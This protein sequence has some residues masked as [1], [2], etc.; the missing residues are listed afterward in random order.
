MRSLEGLNPRQLEAAQHLRGPLLIIAGP[1]SGK[2]RVIV[3]RIAYLVELGNSPYRILAVTFTNKAAREMRER[4]ESLL[5]L[6]VHQLTVGTFHATCARWLRQHIHRLGMDPGFAIYDDNDQVDLVKQVL[7][8]MGVDDKRHSPRSFLSRISAAKAELVGPYQFAERAEGHWEEMCAQVYRRYQQLLLQNRALDFDDLLAVTVQLFRQHPDV[9]E[10][11]QER[12]LHLLVDEFQDTNVAQYELVKLLGGKHRNVC[13]VGDPDQSIYSWRAADI[14]NILNFERDYPDLKV[15]VLEQNYRS[16]QTIL[17]VAHAVISANRLRKD[18]NLW[19]QNERGRPVSVYEAYDERDE[20]LYVVREV[21]RQ[22]ARGAQLRDFAVMYR[23]NAQSRALED[24]FVRYGVPYRLVGGTRFYERRE[25]KDVLAYLRVL[26]NPH[27]SV[28][29]GRILNVPNRGL[30]PKTAMELARWASVHDISL[31]EA[32]RRAATEADETFSGSESP[33]AL[34]LGSRSRHLLGEF[35]A[36][37]D[38]LR[39]ELD[40]RSLPDLIDLLLERTG[41]MH[42]IRDGS[43]EGEERWSNIGELRAKARE[44]EDLGQGGLT[45]FLEEVS[46]VQDVDSYDDRANAVTLITLHAAKGLEFPCV[47]IVGLEEGLCPHSRSFDDPTAM[48]EERRLFYVGI[49]R[50]MRDLH[51]VYSFRRARWGS[52]TTSEPSRFLADIP[53]SLVRSP[54][55]GKG[56]QA[57]GR[58][59]ASDSARGVLSW[60]RGTGEG[61][62]KG[63]QE[64]PSGADIQGQRT[65]RGDGVAKFKTGDTVFHPSLGRGIVITSEASAGDEIVTVVFE[66]HGLKKLSTSFAPLT[67]S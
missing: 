7:K 4:L 2:T 60:A 65:G 3:H 62:G 5:G 61:A 23:T 66:R 28:S 16:T 64:E 26:H 20:A 31:Y 27:D 8:E 45:S 46:L 38:G 55:D 13:V 17:H 39:G 18:K 54:G 14:R 34:R 33:Q 37:L 1:G 29:L 11:F 52:Y 9:L 24:A 56:D 35:L 43:E 41:Y 25:V 57:G 40:R 12:Y 19:T 30:G 58:A 50:A 44:Y 53:R 15:V 36:L 63:S 42:Y 51:L 10:R 59:R 32:V 48:E 22:V 6:S 21:E 49:T 47:F 67:R